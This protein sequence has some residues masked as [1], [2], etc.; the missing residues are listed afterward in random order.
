M[1]RN[2]VFK[3]ADQLSLPVPAGTVSGGPVKV[4]D[5]IGV[6]QTD[7]GDG[8]NDA[9]NATVWLYGS[10]RI[11]V[12]GALASV[13]TPVYITSTN[14]LTATASGNT[15]FGHALE[16]KGAGTTPAIVRVRR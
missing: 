4:G 5:L 3:N 10:Y 2:E 11:P 9:G 15:L 13:G 1:A 6:A 7:R 16:A 8:G 14:T 12:E